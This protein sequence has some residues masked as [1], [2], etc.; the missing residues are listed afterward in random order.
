MFKYFVI[1]VLC[2]LFILVFSENVGHVEGKLFPVVSELTVYDF[3][4]LPPPAYR[5]KF[6]GHADKLRDCNWVRTEW[7]LGKRGSLRVPVVFDYGEKPRLNQVGRIF[8]GDMRISLDPFE[9]LNNSHA[10]V[11]HDCGW[12]WLT[13]TPFYDSEETNNEDP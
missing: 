7:Y 11:I 13:R 3:E 8:W 6:K 10:D 2:S 5:H 9:V 4:P 1:G 12:P